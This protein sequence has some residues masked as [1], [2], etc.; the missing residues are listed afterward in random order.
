MI[1]G[2]PKRFECFAAR[3]AQKNYGSE[4]YGDGDGGGDGDADADA[5]GEADADG[6]GDGEAAA[7]VDGDGVMSEQA[8]SNLPASI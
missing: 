5:D 7:E 4:S 3:T 2:W 8:P 1:A 6:D